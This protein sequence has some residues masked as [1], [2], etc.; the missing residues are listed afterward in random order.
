MED[1]RAAAVLVGSGVDEMLGAL[2]QLLE[3]S[4]HPKD[5]VCGCL[6]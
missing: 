4:D 3:V 6:R 2:G 5:F 1:D